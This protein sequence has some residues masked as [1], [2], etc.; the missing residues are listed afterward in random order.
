MALLNKHL[1][2]ALLFAPSCFIIDNAALS[3][4]ELPP[5][6]SKVDVLPHKSAA[7]HALCILELLEAGAFI[8][9][10]TLP[11]LMIT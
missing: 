10:A 4:F 11:G 8:L 9:P 2:K 7:A 5:G 3:S 1:Q 6:F